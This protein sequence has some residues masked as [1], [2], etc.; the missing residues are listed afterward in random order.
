LR[1]PRSAIRPVGQLF[2][3]A[4]RRLFALWPAW[5]PGRVGHSDP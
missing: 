5:A 3:V 2:T 4:L 1:P